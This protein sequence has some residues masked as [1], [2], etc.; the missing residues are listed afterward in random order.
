K[1]R[2]AGSPA[3]VERSGAIGSVLHGW[4]VH[5]PDERSVFRF[6]RLARCGT[7][8]WLTNG[9]CPA[10]QTSTSGSREKLLM[11]NTAT[12]DSVVLP[13]PRLDSL[14]QAENF[15]R[16]WGENARRTVRGVGFHRKSRYV[17]DCVLVRIMM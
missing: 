2:H 17:R 10:R 15:L 3:G 4:L 5:E 8:R 9:C 14:Q 1:G 7:A 12:H 11:T 13:H 16:F 6:R